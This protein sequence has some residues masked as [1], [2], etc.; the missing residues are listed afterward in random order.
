M[1]ICL[2][3]AAGCGE[4]AAGRSWVHSLTLVGV[5]HVDRDDLEGKLAVEKTSWIPLAPKHYLDPFTLELD[6]KRVESFYQLH[7]FYRAHVTALEV[8]QRDPSSVDV[9]IVI[10]EGPATKIGK[11]SLDGVDVL[12]SDRPKVI[13]GF[14]FQR[15]QVFDDERFTRSVER[16]EAELKA[17]GY[18]WER[19]AATAEVNRDTATANLTVSVSPGQKTV[20]GKISSTGNFT[21]ARRL[22]IHS[23]LLIGDLLTPDGIEA[24]RGKLYNLGVFSSVKADYAPLTGR[25]GE[26]EVTLHVQEGPLRELRLGGGF[27]LE[28]QRTEVRLRGIYTRRNF[29]GG[30]RTVRLTLEPAWVAIPA[31]WNLQKQ[32]PAGKVEVQFTQP[33][34]F[35]PLDQLKIT[36]AYSLGIDYAYQYHGPSTQ[37][38]YARPFFHDKLHLSLSW[39]LQFLFF[40][41]TDPAILANPEQARR[42]LGFTDPYRLGWW[43]QDV[44]LDLRDAPLDPHK[45]AYLSF[46]VEEGGAYAGG[47]FQYEKLQP[48]ARAY[49]PLG[50][51]V[52]V[53]ARVEAGQIYVQGD[54]GSPITRRF[55]LGGPDS[56][57]G[58]GYD[59]LSTQLPSGLPGVPALPIGGDQMFLGQAE[60]RV[61]VAQ[62]FGYWL[63]AAAF[64]DAGDVS[65]PSCQS[66]TTSPTACSAL[67]PASASHLD[68][69]RLHYATGGGLRY[70]TVIGTIRA[71]LGVRLNRLAPTESDGTP[72]PDPGSRFA[73]HISI[74]EPF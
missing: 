55:F 70:K 71:D 65:A 10:E 59:R 14:D 64:L 4:R 74:G 7:G 60:L 32:G 33:D 20:I 68:L 49:V 40:F 38:A 62:L 37:V 36:A 50:K 6:R 28:F 29:L 26:A 35:F 34:L 44:V 23:G 5:R 8:K 63:E 30:L 41:N 17:L 67:G 9:R 15:G 72:N 56:H 25:P 19:V 46:T 66:S 21:D 11:V 22:E 13:E 39:N 48:E 58:F 53:A 12:A 52:V 69:A 45:G 43:Q 54:L 73:F 57:R 1:G 47:A 51:R 16:M 2:V 24:A 61:S 42:L 18:A 31:F 27:G 3:L